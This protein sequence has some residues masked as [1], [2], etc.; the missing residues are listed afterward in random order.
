MDS[1]HSGIAPPATVRLLETEG[2][3]FLKSAVF[4]FLPSTAVASVGPQNGFVHLGLGDFFFF[5]R[6][7][8]V[9]CYS[10]R[11]HLVGY[12]YS[13]RTDALE[14]RESIV[15]IRITCSCRG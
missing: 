4:G 2:R 7:T 1:V 13:S 9:F 6:F 10:T 15:Y 3:R 5:L 11:P 12:D 8:A 14:H